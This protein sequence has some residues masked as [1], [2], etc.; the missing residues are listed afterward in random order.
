MSLS[1]LGLKKPSAAPLFFKLRDSM[2]EVGDLVKT[3]DFV[4]LILEK[5][6]MKH[7]HGERTI[8]WYTI[9]FFDEAEFE[10]R[11][12]SEVNIFPLDK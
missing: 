2:F 12:V 9:D 4:G 10:P 3:R 7:T 11:I 5:N 1:A 8:W 6:A